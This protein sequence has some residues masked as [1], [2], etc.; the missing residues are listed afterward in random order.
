M[1]GCAEDCDPGGALRK[2][3]LAMK[4]GECGQSRDPRL[5]GTWLAGMPRNVQLSLSDN[6]DHSRLADA[7]R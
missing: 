4:R 3:G 2:L 1:R 7:G 5:D 6:S